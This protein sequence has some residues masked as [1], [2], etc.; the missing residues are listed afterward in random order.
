MVDAVTDDFDRLLAAHLDDTLDSTETARFHECL[1][2]D[3]QA[4]QLLLAAS[5]Q[6]SAL[7]RL[8]LE[9]AVRRRVPSSRAWWWLPGTAAAAAALL[10]TVVGWWSTT[11]IVT[12]VRLAGGSALVERGGAVLATPGDVRAGDRLHTGMAPVALMWPGGDTRIDL[13][14]DSRL[15]VEELGLYKVLRLDH[16]G[17]EAA[18]ASQPTDGGLTI[19]TPHGRVEV[20]GT[21]FSVQV[22]EYASRVAVTHGRVRMHPLS[23]GSPVMIDAGYAADL[24]PTSISSPGPAMILPPAAVVPTP[25]NPVA[26]GAVSSTVRI[27]AADFTADAEGE[28]I[29]GVPRS[30]PSTDGGFVVA[31]IVRGVPI[32]DGRVTRL[33]TPSRRP[34]GYARLS[35]NLRCTVRL[36][37]D[38]PT[39]LAVLLVCDQPGGE[40]MWTG[41][42]Q[43]ERAIPVGTHEITFGRSDLRLATGAQPVVGS[44]VVAAAVMCWGAAADLQLEWL[45]F[46]E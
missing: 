35:D 24:T 13:A 40:A 29:N 12:E 7:P 14:G 23:G 3:A 1:R 45:A 5:T 18:V 42:L 11:S 44:R 10:I 43:A 4:R 37:V 30:V 21:R 31:G 26:I 33:I 20:V 36:T 25:D 28:V 22:Q 19:V 17:L 34:N 46:S 16:G 8:G 9:A 15:Q 27:T 6:A 2:S 39:T 32:A 41:N 38:R